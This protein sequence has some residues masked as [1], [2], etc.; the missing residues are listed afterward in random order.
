M[1][2]SAYPHGQQGPMPLDGL[3]VLAFRLPILLKSRTRS[4][5]YPTEALSERT[6]DG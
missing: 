1:L 4:V 3:A 5:D 2:R 6:R